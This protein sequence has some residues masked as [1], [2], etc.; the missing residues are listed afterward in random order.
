[1]KFDTTNMTTV[2]EPTT[3]SL[4]QEIEDAGYNQEAV[5]LWRYNQGQDLYILE[6]WQDWIDQFEEAY[7]GQMNTEDFAAQLA[8]ECYLGG[9][10]VPQWVVTYF[11]YE[12]FER[13]LFLGDY[14]ESEGHI[15]RSY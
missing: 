13:D 12:K 4:W 3:Q 14:W 15:F 5:S 8:D 6:E 9:K 11:D 2:T 1:M 7:C 10:D